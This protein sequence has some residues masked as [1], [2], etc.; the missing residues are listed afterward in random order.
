[1]TVLAPGCDN[2]TADPWAC[3]DEDIPCTED[4]YRGKAD[5]YAREDADPGNV[6][7]YSENITILIS[8]YYHDDEQLIELKDR[9]AIGDIGATVNL[10]DTSFTIAAETLWSRDG[11][12]LNRLARTFTGAIDGPNIAGSITGYNSLEAGAG[13]GP[14]TG[15]FWAVWQPD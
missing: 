14:Q 13:S 8:Y 10:D 15:A 4:V 9:T 11:D 3:M 6:T 7:H 5:V 1:M 12:E 2:E